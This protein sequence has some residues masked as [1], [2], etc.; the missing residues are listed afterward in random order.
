MITYQIRVI[1]ARTIDVVL[2]KRD[3]ALARSGPTV[4]VGGVASSVGNGRRADPIG[5]IALDEAILEYAEASIE[6]A[7]ETTAEAEAN[8]K[9]VLAY[10]PGLRIGVQVADDEEDRAVAIG[11]AEQVCTACE[12][13][14]DPT[15]LTCPSCGSYHLISL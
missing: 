10:P 7:V 13:T 14:C 11:I 6:G 4:P 8:H 9:S 1:A 3:D 2:D 15:Y 5:Q 12:C